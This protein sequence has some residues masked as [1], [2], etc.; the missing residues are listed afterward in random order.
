M[1]DALHQILLLFGLAMFFG[2][3]GG[4][5]FR[6]FRIPQVVGYIT[7]GIILGISGIGIF[8]RD[9]QKLFSAR[10]KLLNR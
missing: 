10:V 1:N 2:L 8:D 4:K 9:C 3:T 7:I 5:I 6:H